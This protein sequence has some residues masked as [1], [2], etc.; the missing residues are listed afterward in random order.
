MDLGLADR[1]SKR[2][3]GFRTK[4][5][6]NLRF[7]HNRQNDLTCTSNVSIKERNIYLNI[8]TT[9]SSTIGAHVLGSS[10][11]SVPLLLLL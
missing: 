5:V 8:A 4:L 9:K 7:R 6:H 3:A 1:R 10:W 11:S 2:S